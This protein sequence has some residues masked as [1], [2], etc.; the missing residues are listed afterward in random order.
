MA[1][2]AP[3]CGRFDQVIP[4]LTV[5]QGIGD[6]LLTKIER[7]LLSRLPFRTRLS[8]AGL[9]LRRRAVAA[10][11]AASIFKATRSDA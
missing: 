4:H 8:E 10:S 1:A 2:G 6:P 7:D 9:R 3:Y 11:S 5:A